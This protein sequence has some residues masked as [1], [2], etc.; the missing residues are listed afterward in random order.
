MASNARS[1]PRPARAQLTI[2]PEESS[3]L[4]SLPWELQ[5]EII[6]HLNVRSALWLRQTC[7][8]YFQHLSVE[9]IE[10]IFTEDGYITF[11]L[12]NCCIECLATPPIGYLIMDESRRQNAWRSLC[13]RCWRVKRSPDHHLKPNRTL[14]FVSGRN[15]RACKFCGW[16]VCFNVMHLSCRRMVLAMNGVWWGLSAVHFSLLIFTI[17]A[18]WI[19]Y[20]EVPAVIIPATLNFFMAFASLALLT[21]DMLQNSNTSN[22]RLCMEL[23]STLIWTPAVFHSASEISDGGASWTSYPVFICGLFAARLLTHA[24]NIVGFSILSSGYDT[25]S[26]SFPG[27]S[28][29]KRAL[30][31]VYSFLVYWACVKYR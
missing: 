28:F 27:L 5:L 26:P 22:C 9:A 17:T 1:L 14:S 23:T 3:P 29:R 6:S 31:V 4:T 7:Q 12:L 2:V 25:R 21:L 16:P 11:D 10:K 18:A 15:G 8:L 13:F 19:N 30:Y 20:A 24:M